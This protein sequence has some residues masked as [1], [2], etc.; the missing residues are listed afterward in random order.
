MKKI[1]MVNICAVGIHLILVA[2]EAIT[3]ARSILI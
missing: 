2:L 1:E 3:K